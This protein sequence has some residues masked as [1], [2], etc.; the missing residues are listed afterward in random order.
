MSKSSTQTCTCRA[1]TLIELLVVVSIIALLIAIL[2]PALAK[3]RESAKD[4][5]CKSN[6]KQ[7]AIAQHAFTADNDGKFT[8]PSG[9]E[10]PDGAIVPGWV[11]ASVGSIW[12]DPTMIEGVTEGALF[13][14]VNDSTAIYLC[15]IAADVLV[16][17]AGSRNDKLV[18]NYV[19]NWNLGAKDPSTSYPHDE[20]TIDS[21]RRPSDLVLQAE[22]NTY[23]IAGYSRF[24]LNDGALM[25]RDGDGARA[26]IRQRDCFGSFHYVNGVN[27]DPASVALAASYTG[28]IVTSGKSQASFVDG[29]VQVV[30]YRFEGTSATW[31]SIADVNGNPQRVSNTSLFCSDDINNSY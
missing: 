31:L 20:N 12:G 28:P 26:S 3:A 4:M 6:L 30:D 13:D 5:Q 10:K 23:R 19:Q 18:R 27:D 15:P 25:G 9:W 17:P 14:Y 2:L 7:L 8:P 1:F 22:E 16:P 21:V 11:N 29:S 24:T